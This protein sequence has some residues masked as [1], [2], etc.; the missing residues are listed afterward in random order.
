MTSA[1]RWP[2]SEGTFDEYNFVPTRLVLLGKKLHV[3]DGGGKLYAGDIVDGLQG[4]VS[5]VDGQR[6]K[7]SCGVDT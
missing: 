7:G 6:H 3:S 1:C 5:L 2:S 4:E